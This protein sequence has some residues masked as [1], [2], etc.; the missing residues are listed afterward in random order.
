MKHQLLPIRDQ[1]LRMA[2]AVNL[3]QLLG[4]ACEHLAAQPH[5]AQ[6][7]QETKEFKE[8][9]LDLGIKLHLNRVLAIIQQVWGVTELSY[10]RLE[11]QG[12]K[13][14]KTNNLSARQRN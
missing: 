6:A 9:K 3:K 11:V 10:Q 2:L 4:Q 7:M 14:I 8:D 1:Q 13:R 5:R 12:L